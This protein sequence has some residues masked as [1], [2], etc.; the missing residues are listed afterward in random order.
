MTS[1]NVVAK[2]QRAKIRAGIFAAYSI[3]AMIWLH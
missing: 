1:G 2:M 3:V